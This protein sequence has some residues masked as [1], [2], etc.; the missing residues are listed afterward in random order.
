M[1]DK[2]KEN[3]QQQEEHHEP[4]H[5]EPVHEAEEAGGGEQQ[6]IQPLGN[7]GAQNIQGEPQLLVVPGNVQGMGNEAGNEVQEN[8]A[9]QIQEVQPEVQEEQAPVNQP[10]QVV[11]EEQAPANQAPQQIQEQKAPAAKVPVPPPEIGF[12]LGADWGSGEVEEN[13]VV[14]VGNR[15]KKKGKK[16]NN[17]RNIMNDDD[18]IE[19]LEALDQGNDLIIADNAMQPVRNAGFTPVTKK[20]KKP[21]FFRR[22]Y[23]RFT[24]FVGRLTGTAV[25]VLTSPYLLVKGTSA[26]V[27]MHNAKK[28][29]QEKKNYGQ[30]PGWGG[31][32]F[33]KKNDDTGKDILLDQRRVPAVWSYLTAGKAVDNEGKPLPPEVSVYFDQPYLGSSKTFR[34]KEIGHAMLG[35]S[36]SRY[37][38]FTNR[39]ERYHMRYGF[40]MQGGFTS[41]DAQNAMDLRNARVP[42]EL[43]D[44]RGHTY[45]ISRRYPAKPAQVNSIVKASETYAEGGYGYFSR[46]CTTFVKEMVVDVGKLDT[47]G[48]IF[49]KEDVKYNLYNN[50]LRWGG[51]TIDPFLQI[52]ISNNMARRSKEDD[53]SY[54]NYG[55]KRVTREDMK[56]Y[57][58]T[59]TIFTLSPKTYSPA[60]AGENARRLTGKK[61]GIM[62]SFKYAGNLGDDVIN[63]DLSP[64]RLSEA[65]A[66]A[67]TA[68]ANSIEALFPPEQQGENLPKV[69]LDT[70]SDVFLLG[71]NAMVDLNEDYD[72]KLDEAANDHAIEDTKLESLIEADRFRDAHEKLSND[73]KKV[74][75]IYRDILKADE[76]LLI[77]VTNLLSIY[78]LC[79]SFLDVTYDDAS[80]K[81]FA[82]GDLGNIREEMERTTIKLKTGDTEVEFTPSHYESYIQIYKTPEKAIQAY[83]QFLDLKERKD[84]AE[85]IA[86]QEAGAVEELEPLSKAEKKDLK[87]LEQMEELAKSFDKSHNYLLERPGFKQQD[88]DYAFSLAEKEKAGLVRQPGKNNFFAK[89]TSASGIYKALFLE[90]LYGGIKEIWFSGEQGGAPSDEALTELQKDPT[91]DNVKRYISPWLDQFLTDRTQQKRDGMKMIVKGIYR[92]AKGYTK[93]RIVTYIGD[94]IKTCYLSRVFSD[95]GNDRR[96][97]A[98]EMLVANAMNHIIGN[99]EMKFPPLLSAIVDEVIAKEKTKEWEI[100]HSGRKR[101]RR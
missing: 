13:T 3:L 57:D 34:G 1:A 93:D 31:A 5:V 61:A 68:F 35:I 95:L 23:D 42:G 40:Y 6:V 45:T 7:E 60:V 86:N 83:A 32:K 19:G 67:I 91:P 80:K 97:H 89:G 12:E 46:N 72:A 79:L 56:N 88:I 24:V 20:R 22:L 2:D 29:M 52:G 50:F 16:K 27:R 64:K 11:Q 8:L 90:R 28:K 101:G 58:K 47:D 39:Y 75:D 94:M 87:K 51:A 71:D 81:A 65:L 43:H 17:V 18:R 55:N 30:I 85:K 99:D 15:K 100:L 78:E 10:P 26:A 21:G 37:S 4:E 62:G 77:P 73:Q 82:T 48:T 69:I 36:Y 66:D 70:V 44:D 92:S 14:A 84:N 38:R 49:E 76:R 33:K 63:A 41:A 74:S 9:P 98:G 59:N 25:T 54:Q 53:L 96:A